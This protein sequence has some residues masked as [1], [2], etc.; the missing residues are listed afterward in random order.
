MLP[1]TRGVTILDKIARLTRLE[2]DASVLLLAALGAAADSRH[3]DSFPT[4][5][6][7]E[8]VGFN[9]RCRA[10]PFT[11]SYVPYTRPKV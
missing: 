10:W 5:T 7:R 11:M 1:L 6:W 3:H 2:I 8:R 4:D 9:V